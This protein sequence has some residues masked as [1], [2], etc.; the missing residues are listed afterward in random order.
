MA[1]PNEMKTARMKAPEAPPY[2]TIAF[3]LKPTWVRLHQDDHR[4][5][6][7]DDRQVREDNP[8]ER[9]DHVVPDEGNQHLGDHNDR[10]GHLEAEDGVVVVVR[11][12]RQL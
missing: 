11:D 4:C 12:R 5:E 1:Y 7:E 2:G 6:S 8:L 10:E 9:V 3:G